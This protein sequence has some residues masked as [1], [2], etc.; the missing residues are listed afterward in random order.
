[1]YQAAYGEDLK[2]NSQKD[3]RQ[4][5]NKSLEQPRSGVRAGGRPAGGFGSHYDQGAAD[6]RQAA[7]R[8]VAQQEGRNHGGSGFSSHSA[9]SAHSRNVSQEMT[10]AMRLNGGGGPS[11]K[12]RLQLAHVPPNKPAN[13]LNIEKFMAGQSLPAAR[14]GKANEKKGLALADPQPGKGLHGKTRSQLRLPEFRHGSQVKQLPPHAYAF[15]A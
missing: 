15:Q 4:R 3:K 6:R 8:G 10:A 13:T 11:S 1:M 5:A 7:G 14:M 2:E 9:E 12:A